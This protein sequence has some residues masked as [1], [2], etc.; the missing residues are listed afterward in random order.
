MDEKQ[1]SEKFLALLN[2]CDWQLEEDIANGEY[3]GH[4]EKRTAARLRHHKEAEAA[5]YAYVAELES[6]PIG[7]N[8]PTAPLK[9]DDALYWCGRLCY[10]ITVHSNGDERSYN[11]STSKNGNLVYL[12]IGE[13]KLVNMGAIKEADSE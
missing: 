12:G 5:L 7:D 1:P 11:L 9:V 6:R 13:W 10:V 4:N 2:E 8:K 3:I